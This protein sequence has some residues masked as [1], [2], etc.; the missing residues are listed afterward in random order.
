MAADEKEKE[1]KEEKETEKESTPQWAQKLIDLL[2]PQQ[3]AE[4]QKQT[5][6]V[7]NQPATV[8]E[9][10]EQEEQEQ[11]EKKQPNLAKKI[12]DFLL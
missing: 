5:V 7:P 1:E 10:E 9:Q 4:N 12:W 8:E 11:E 6:P 2:T 3:Q